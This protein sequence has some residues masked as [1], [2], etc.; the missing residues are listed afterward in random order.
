MLN[1][2]AYLGLCAALHCWATLGACW[3]EGRRL[4]AAV[5]LATLA[6]LLG[7]AAV[8]GGGGTAA[9]AG[10]GPAAGTGGGAAGAGRLIA[11]L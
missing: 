5:L 7:A 6:D 9:S 3:W 10:P 4:A 8:G 1:S 2:A 11:S